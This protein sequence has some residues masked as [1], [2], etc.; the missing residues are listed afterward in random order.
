MLNHIS[1]QQYI[2]A[3]IFIAAVWYGWVL[4][5]YYKPKPKAV[6][7]T[8]PVANQMTV[9]MGAVKADTDTG[10]H[11]PE[12]LRFSVASP[13]A[14]SEQTLPKGPG[15]ELLEE[16]QTLMTAYADN[17]DKKSFLSLLKILLNKYEV[18]AD[19]ISLPAIIKQLKHHHLPF[20]IA[21]NEWPLTFEA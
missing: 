15:D 8:P 19:E 18:F 6:P 4:F 16:A 14:I 17:E 13:D 20:T 7:P 9:V 21:D 5:K 10:V 1:W 11:G 2:S 3:V 12:E